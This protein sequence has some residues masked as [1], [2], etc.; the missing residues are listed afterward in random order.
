MKIKPIADSRIGEPTHCFEC[1]GCG[2][3]HGVWVARQGYCGPTW[4]FN[5]DLNNPTIHPSILVRV[6]TPSGIKVCH[7]FIRDGYIQ[8]LN[9]C[10]HELKGQTIE[11]PTI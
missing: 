6:P 7:S 9:D 5:M 3:L 8:Y 10:T 11:L 4:D 2:C 1:P